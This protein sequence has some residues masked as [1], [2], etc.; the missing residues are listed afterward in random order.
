MATTWTSWRHRPPVVSMTTRLIF[1]KWST[2]N[3]HQFV[4]RSRRINADAFLHNLRNKCIKKTYYRNYSIIIFTVLFYHIVASPGERT[5]V[6]FRRDLHED[7]GPG[8][9][10]WVTSI[11]THL[12]VPIHSQHW[13]EVSCFWTEFFLME[14]FFLFG[15]R[16]IR[17]VRLT[18]IVAYEVR[19]LN[20]RQ[21]LHVFL[22][23]DFEKKLVCALNTKYHWAIIKIIYLI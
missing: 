15:V 22:I 10:W 23:T 7:P 17:I 8:V 11:R 12:H 1:P 18:A 21:P 14:V 2:C 20:K 6:L 5:P 9:R 3:H 4:S 16:L 13:D 19:I